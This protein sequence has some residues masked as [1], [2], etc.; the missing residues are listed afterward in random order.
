MFSIAF[1]CVD[2]SACSSVSNVIF[3][4]ALKQGFYLGHSEEMEKVKILGWMDNSPMHGSCLFFF[5][6]LS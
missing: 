6:F 1:H 4:S 5:F 2:A 3:L